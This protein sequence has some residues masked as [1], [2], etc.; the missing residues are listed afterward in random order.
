[1][2]Q[3]GRPHATA[4]GS[5]LFFGCLPWPPAHD[6]LG[7]PPGGVHFYGCRVGA[8]PCKVASLRSCERWSRPLPRGRP[9]P[10]PA[11]GSL[12]RPVAVE[13]RFASLAN[14]AVLR[15]GYG[16]SVAGA[17]GRRLARELVIDPRAPPP[18][19]A[20]RAAAVDDE[21]ELLREPRGRRHELRF[22]ARTRWDFSDVK[23][24]GAAR[25]R[26]ACTAS[27]RS[28]SCSSPTTS[29]SP[30]APTAS[31]VSPMA[32][33]SETPRDRWTRGGEV[34]RRPLLSAIVTAVAR[35]RH[36]GVQP[37]R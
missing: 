15:G 27:S 14:S 8:S 5:P 37:R 11:P 19:S 18:A 32:G 12:S 9:L 13:T 30:S 34:S 22:R 28:R 29:G 6:P 26:P 3:R 16:Q 24:R 31:F 25:R 10:P 17:T 7:K 4:Y 1:M 2:R 23:F 35:A 20:G 33:C 21:G 36:P